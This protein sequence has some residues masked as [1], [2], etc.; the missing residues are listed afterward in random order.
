MLR[1]R[2]DKKNSGKL[3]PIVAL[4]DSD[5]STYDVSELYNKLEIA[6]ATTACRNSALQ[7]ILYDV[8]DFCDDSNL[9]K[10]TKIR[11]TYLRRE[12]RRL[13]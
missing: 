10:N 9:L 1:L 4:S 11:V 2:L 3:K 6:K 7:S 5:S 12:L 8:N 13:Y